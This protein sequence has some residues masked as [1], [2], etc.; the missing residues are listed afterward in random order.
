MPTNGEY[1]PPGDSIF[2][3]LPLRSLD[4]LSLQHKL[5]EIGEMEG[6][7]TPPEHC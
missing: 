5:Q 7:T 1:S 3:A 2:A 4:Q 6:A